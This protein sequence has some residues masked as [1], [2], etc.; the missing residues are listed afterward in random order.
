MNTKKELLELAAEVGGLLA[1]A[2]LRVDEQGIF[3]S[4][5]ASGVYGMGELLE[6]LATLPGDR[7]PGDH[8]RARAPNADHRN[9]YD[10]E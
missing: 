3:I 9:H 8:L 5:L 6:M 1:T 7:H 2:L 10:G 4:E